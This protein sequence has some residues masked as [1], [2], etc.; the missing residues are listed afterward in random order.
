MS[1]EIVK[2]VQVVKIDDFQIIT[3]KEE[4]KRFQLS[5]DSMGTDACAVVDYDDG[6]ERSYGDPGFCKEWQP[7]VKYDPVFSDLESPQII[8]KIY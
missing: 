2:K 8:S 1:F 7:K 5:Y 4:T 6:S 3:S